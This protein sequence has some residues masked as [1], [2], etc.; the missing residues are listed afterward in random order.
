MVGEFLYYAGAVDPTMLAALRKLAAAQSK[1]TEETKKV[2]GHLLDYCTTN[3]Y[4]KLI[5]HSR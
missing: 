4:S 2:V 5:F 1:G 3:P